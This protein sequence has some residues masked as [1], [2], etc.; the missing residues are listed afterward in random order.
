MDAGVPTLNDIVLEVDRQATSRPI[1]ELQDLRKRLHG[2]IQ[3]PT[4][5]VFSRA[6][7][8]I[9]TFH[10]GG[11][12]ELQFNLGIEEPINGLDLRYGV[13]FS[14]E[15]SRPLPSIDPLLPRVA[16]FNDYVREKF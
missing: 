13:A 9:W 11:R 5:S 2:L 1:G 3:K 12:E 7:T 4:R 16:L 15:L 8:P 14:L 10:A 6:R